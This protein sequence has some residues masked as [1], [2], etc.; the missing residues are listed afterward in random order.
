MTLNPFSWYVERLDL[1]RWESEEPGK[2]SGFFGCPVH[3]GSD[4]L[5]VTEKNGKALVKCFACDAD[6]FA[7]T[8]ALET[9]PEQEPE[10]RNGHAPVTITRSRGG[11]RKPGRRSTSAAQERGVRP[12]AAST[13]SPLDWMAS[14]C[15]IT[16]AELD[17]LAL[18]LSEQEGFLVFDFPGTDSAKFRGVGEGKKEKQYGWSGPAAP[19]LWPMPSNPG[20][21]IVVTEGEADA[22]C[23]RHS[24]LEAYSVT[25]GSQGEVPAVVWEALRSAGV[26]TVRLV[27]DLDKAGRSGRDDAAEGAR[28]AGLHVLESR[29]VGIRPLA[30]E[31]D[32]RDVATRQ[33]Y[34]LEVEDDADEDL[35]VLLSDIDPV[36]PEPPL[37]DKLHPFEHTILFGD[38]GTGKGVIAAW[39]VAQLTQLGMRVLVVDYEMHM[40]YEW[41]PRVEG[42]G[43]HMS[44]VA[45]VQPHQPVWEIAGWL[46]T[47]AAAYDYVVVDSVTYACIGEEVEKSVTATKYSS[48]IN[49]MQK[50][51]LSIAHVTKQSADPNHPFGSIFWSNGARVTVAVSRQKPED[52]ESPRVLRNA[53]TNQ[54]GPFRTVEI[55]WSWLDNDG[56]PGCDCRQGPAPRHLHERQSVPN[57]RRMIQEGRDR[58][59]AIHGREPTGPELHTMLEQEFGDEA[60]KA[61]HVSKELSLIRRNTA[62]RLVRTRRD[63]SVG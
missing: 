27:F 46:R 32:A 12:P 57:A 45:V 16:R 40:Q 56:P 19:P 41:R 50:P 31:T 44:Q 1:A 49:Q 23:L 55:D 33:G 39:W 51:V 6:V 11:A 54:R 5:H 13:T 35:P 21:D 47:Q 38:G 2:R 15:A 17:D 29:V 18:P 37:L 60:P 10:E 9:L 28:A 4:S 58:F 62:P 59:V 25:K 52:P 8:A 14:R 43:G 30:G 20:S 22:I 7:V 3:G 53:K 34:P 63:P 48:A 24:G 26:E 42:F 61:G 36:L